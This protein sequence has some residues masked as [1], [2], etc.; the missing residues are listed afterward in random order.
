M[1]ANNTYE[2]KWKLLDE[3]YLKLDFRMLFSHSLFIN[4]SKQFNVNITYIN[5]NKVKV[6]VKGKAIPVTG[7]ED[8]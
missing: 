5:T 6:N 8:P 1:F 4:Y 2:C 7:R 3:K